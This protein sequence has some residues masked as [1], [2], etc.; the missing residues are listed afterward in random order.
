MNC[1]PTQTVAVEEIDIP[2]M[3]AKYAQERARRLRD[4]GQ[5]QYVRP[6][7]GVVEDFTADPHMP[8]QPRDPISEDIDVAVLGAGWGGI[9]A[10]INRLP[11]PSV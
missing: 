10:K 9:L 11:V 4:A 3:R 7:G 5:A 1:K 2:A 8:V 6:T